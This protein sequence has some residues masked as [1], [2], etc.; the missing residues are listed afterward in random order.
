MFAPVCTHIST[1]ACIFPAGTASSLLQYYDLRLTITTCQNKYHRASAPTFD[2]H[3]NTCAL[4]PL[5]KTQNRGT[6]TI[7]IRGILLPT[8]HPGGDHTLEGLTVT[9]EE[10]GIMWKRLNNLQGRQ[11]V[12]PVDTTYNEKHSGSAGLGIDRVQSPPGRGRPPP[13][14]PREDMPPRQSAHLPL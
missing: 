14:P 1:R 12:S 8:T 6:R 11:P 10:L 13:R 4:V 2:V 9:T 7:R 3:L 5:P